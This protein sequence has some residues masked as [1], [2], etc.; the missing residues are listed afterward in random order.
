MDLDKAIRERRSIRRYTEQ[1]ISTTD[2]NAI[3]DAARWSP[4]SG[5]T[6]S[7][8]FIVVTDKALKMTMLNFMPGVS[9]VPAAIILICIEA[10]QKRVKE[11]TRL[12]HMADAAIASQNISLSAHSMGIG[13]CIVASFADVALRALFN[14]PEGIAPYI[15]ITLG[16]PAEAPLP[17]PRREIEEIA[18]INEYGESWQS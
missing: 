2:M 5:N 3:L 12:V 1:E 17:P 9:D 10:K 6:N 7:W 18:F 4:N 13:S 16:Y 15:A 11:A 14:V 8:R